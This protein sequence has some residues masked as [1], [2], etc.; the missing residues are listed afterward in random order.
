MLCVAAFLLFAAWS[1]LKR[2]DWARKTFVVLFVLGAAWGGFVFLA[3]GLGMGVFNLLSQPPSS[4]GVP[5]A[6]D[7]AFRI[8]GIMFGVV[9]AGFAVLFAWL[10]K[11]LRSPDTRAEFHVTPLS[12]KPLQDDVRNAR[13]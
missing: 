4:P 3:F 6:F 7:S 9:G 5:T 1:F 8:M 2:R 10:V 11:G 13:A 12:N